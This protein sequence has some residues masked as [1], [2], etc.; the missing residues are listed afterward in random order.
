[1]KSPFHNKN[2][3]IKFWSIKKT[4]RESLRRNHAKLPI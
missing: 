3:N 4:E 2:T 1:M